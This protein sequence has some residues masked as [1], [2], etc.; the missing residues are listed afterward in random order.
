MV[1]ALLVY[2]IL[3]L[4]GWVGVGQRIYIFV[5]LM[6]LLIMAIGLRSLANRGAPGMKDIQI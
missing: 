1:V 6:W 4:I 3:A 2:G 5:S